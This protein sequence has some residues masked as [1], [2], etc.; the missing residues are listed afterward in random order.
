MDGRRPPRPES[1]HPRAML[2]RALRIA[3]P[4]SAAL[5]VVVAITL[6]RGD[7]PAQRFLIVYIAPLSAFSPHDGATSHSRPP[8]AM[9]YMIVETNIHGPAPVYA[10]FRERGRMA[11]DGLVYVSSVVSTDGA[12]CFQLMECDDPRLLDEWMAAWD[13]LVAFEVVPVISSADAAVRF[14]R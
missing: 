7:W 10:R 9:Q 3:G 5:V 13:D 12:R 11:P 2:D 1:D 14:G 4:L 6:R 8:D